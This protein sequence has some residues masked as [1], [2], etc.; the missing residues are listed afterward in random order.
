MYLPNIVK[1][2][3]NRQ[4]ELTK[5][6]LLTDF[7][8][9]VI[10]AI[11]ALPLS[12]ALGISSGVSPEKGLITAI[13]AGFF[14]SFFGGSKVQ[15]GGPTGA[16]V[17]IVY[18]I[19]EKHGIEG[20]IISTFMAGIILIILGLIK[21]GNLIKYIP[22]A[23]TIGF[24][25]GIAITLFSTQ[26]KDF[27]GLHIG[28]VP[29]EFIPKWNMY[30]RNIGSMNFW[31]LALGVL[32]LVI[33]IF[34][35]KINKTIPGSL[36]AL[37]VGTIIAFIFKLP[38]ATI[39]TQFGE[40][41]SSIPMPNVP[42]LNIQT[43]VSLIGPAVTIA[44]LAGIES[45]LSAVVSDGM[46]NEK[47]D[48]NAELIGQGL[49]NIASALF[50]GIPATG[51]I[52]RTAAN[53]KSGGRTPL[54]GMIHAIVLL[55]I[56]KIFMPFIKYVPLTT[57]AGILLVVSYNMSQWRVFKSVLSDSRLDVI[58]LITTF[59]LTVVS[60]LVTAIVVAMVIYL[61][62]YDKILNSTPFLKR[63]VGV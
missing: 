58:L 30:L 31:T 26:V 60:D 20:L 49:G 12:V 40:L 1:L 23:I 44:F 5:K 14:I 48:S 43:F 4:K 13:I 25:A 2:L 15:I 56:M 3:K 52:A 38:V 45:L 11:I 63:K 61:I 16:F 35:G 50:G 22:H 33:I 29:S 34:W 37:I 32:S 42:I 6:Q 7:I 36:I 46:I 18:G 39:G 57:L 10:V 8:S 9:G 27:L 24:T 51:A 28:K 47:H 41:S 54:S 17:V 62:P 19:I 21:A 53:V 55:L 59:S